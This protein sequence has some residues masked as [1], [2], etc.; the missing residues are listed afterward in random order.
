[1][2]SSC[3]WER[4]PKALDCDVR[5]SCMGRWRGGS[6][7]S[8]LQYLSL[9]HKLPDWPFWAACGCECR[10]WRK[11][12]NGFVAPPPSQCIMPKTVWFVSV[13]KRLC[14]FMPL[15]TR[16]YHFWWIK[17][18]KGDYWDEGYYPLL[19]AWNHKIGHKWKHEETQTCLT[20]VHRCVDF[21]FVPKW[22]LRWKIRMWGFPS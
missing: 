22:S 17:L 20:Y 15:G 21:A 6:T 5:G 10:D 14:I 9:W 13:G 19:K 8:R 1:M 12:S 16:S 18:Y 2:G 7:L 4:K 11:L 3:G